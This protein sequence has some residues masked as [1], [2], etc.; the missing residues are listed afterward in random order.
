[1][2]VGT[3]GQTRGGAWRQE[4]RR[5]SQDRTTA[6]DGDMIHWN[7]VF[8]RVPI[9]IAITDPDGRFEHCNAAYSA[10]LGYSELEL[11]ERRFDELIHP[12]DRESN[13]A[14]VGR[15]LRGEIPHFEVENRY[16]RKDGSAVWVHKYCAFV[17]DAS[18]V[19]GSP[20]RLL[21]AVTDITERRALDAALRAKG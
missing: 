9:G 19:A 20:A 3:M 8:D 4:A 21:V 18:A 13:R 5:G 2:P 11:R 17:P 7:R 15:M 14:R 10:L 16:L 6:L 1:M 12:D